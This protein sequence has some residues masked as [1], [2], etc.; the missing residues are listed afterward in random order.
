MINV[1]IVASM[2]IG[3]GTTNIRL[4]QS[5]AVA[6]TGSLRAGVVQAVAS[7]APQASAQ[8]KDGWVNGRATFS[9]PSAE[10]VA[11]FNR[12]GHNRSLQLCAYPAHKRATLWV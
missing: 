1:V 4:V 3:A 11:Q 2:L 12:H 5:E 6:D 8:D 7:S 9:A 10:Y